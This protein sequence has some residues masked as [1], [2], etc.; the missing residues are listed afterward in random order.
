MSW[1]AIWGPQLTCAHGT[2][3]ACLPEHLVYRGDVKVDRSSRLPDILAFQLPIYQV[4]F[5]AAALAPEEHLVR[6]RRLH[7][8]HRGDGSERDQAHGQILGHVTVAVV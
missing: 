3:C 2:A 1:T 6:R 8:G 5:V 7:A 4:L